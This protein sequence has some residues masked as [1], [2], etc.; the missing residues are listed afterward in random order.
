MVSAAPIL[1][2]AKKRDERR[3]IAPF[4]VI[5]LARDFLSRGAFVR[6]LVVCAPRGALIRVRCEGTRCPV[7]AARAA[8]AL[9]GAAAPFAQFERRL[10]AVIRLEIFV[11]QPG[12]I[13]KYTRFLVRAGEP[14]KRVDRCLFP[15]VQRPKACP[16]KAPAGRLLVR[17]HPRATVTAAAALVAIGGAFI[18]ARLVAASGDEPQVQSVRVVTND[19][20]AV[21]DLPALTGEPVAA[22]PHKLGPARADVARSAGAHP[23]SGRA[24]ASIAAG[25]LG[26]CACGARAAGR[27]SASAGYPGAAGGASTSARYPGADPRPRAG[28]ATH[29]A[30]TGW[31][32]RLGMK[33]RPVYGLQVSVLLA[34]RRRLARDGRRGF[35]EI[36]TAAG[37]ARCMSCA[38][39]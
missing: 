29:A 12:R 13:G 6:L 39:A 9:S 14:P 32:R 21:A 26:A 11:R 24:A 27:A 16:V 20:G 10:P 22:L 23:A 8:R 18:T 33:L 25:R 36:A 28:S 19:P 7:K 5:R 34:T 38:I 30:P 1:P 2:A 31:V 4:P 35:L 17:L 15:G 37:G 3:F